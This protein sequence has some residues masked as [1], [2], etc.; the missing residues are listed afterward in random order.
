MQNQSDGRK[1]SRISVRTSPAKEKQKG[2]SAPG[3]LLAV[4]LVG[5]FVL[6]FIYIMIWQQVMLSK[7]NKEIDALEEKI[8]AATQ[9]T[10]QLKEQLSSMEDPEYIERIAREKLGLVRPNERVFVD[11]NKSDSNQSD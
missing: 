6:Y 7:K 10:E 3:R 9:Q 11:A 8:S 5:L 4:V 1:K 2:K